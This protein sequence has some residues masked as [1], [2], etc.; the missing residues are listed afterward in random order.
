LFEHAWVNYLTRDSLVGKQ[1]HWSVVGALFRPL[2]EQLDELVAAIVN[3]RVVVST[4]TVA[5]RRLAAEAL[6]TL[7]S[8]TR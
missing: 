2:H 3:W 6:S 4:T 7:I 5:A 1:F 8:C